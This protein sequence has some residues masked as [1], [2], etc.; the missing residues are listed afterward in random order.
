MFYDCRFQF[1]FRIMY[2][3][4]QS[5]EFGNDWTLYQ[6]VGADIIVF[7]LRRKFG[8]LKMTLIVLRI[9]VSF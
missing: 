4:F 9:D 7:L 3:L 8:L 2:I 6:F 5:K 1:R